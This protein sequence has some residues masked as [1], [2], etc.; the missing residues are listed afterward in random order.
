MIAM[1][2]ILLYIKITLNYLKKVFMTC[3]A[4]VL[5]Y[6]IHILL[7]IMIRDVYIFYFICFYT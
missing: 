1:L 7:V 3:R 4:Y 6:K 5:D 2:D